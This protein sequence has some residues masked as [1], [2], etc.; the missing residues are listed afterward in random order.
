[1]TNITRNQAICMFY[2]KKYTEENVACLS[3][4]LDEMDVDICYLDDPTE[5]FLVWK[6]KINQNPFRYRTYAD[7]TSKSVTMD[8]TSVDQI[9]LTTPAQ[10]VQLLNMVYLAFDPSN[11]DMYECRQ[12]SQKQ[13]L[14]TAWKYTTIFDEKTVLSFT[15][16]CSHKKLDFLKVPAKRRQNNDGDRLTIRY[17]FVLKDQYIG[18]AAKTIIQYLPVYQ[19]YIHKLKDE[20]YTI[21]GYARKSP[22]TDDNKNRIAL[23][24]AMCNKLKE[25]SEVDHIFVSACSKASDP[26]IERDI[27]KDSESLAKLSAIGD[28]QGE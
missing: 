7:E 9:S 28:T 12:V 3:K 20:G 8:G 13:I 22:T 10:V 14:S 16:W 18:P 19:K 4:K 5:S 24:E 2:G 6:T 11:E 17:L 27:K 26:F 23:L 21:V 15:K 25:R 1:M